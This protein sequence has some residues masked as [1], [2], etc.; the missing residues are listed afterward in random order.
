M[1]DTKT[2][3]QRAPPYQSGVWAVYDHTVRGLDV[4][5]QS[6]SPEGSPTRG[7]NRKRR[8][9][10]IKFRGELPYEL[11]VSWRRKVLPGD[12]CCDVHNSTHPGPQS[13]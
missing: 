8:R 3:A 11:L 6:G 13:Q 1:Y 12:F 9:Q 10:W 4:R 2:G 7:A 5:Y